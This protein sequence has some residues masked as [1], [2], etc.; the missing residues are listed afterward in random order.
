MEPKNV[1]STKRDRHSVAIKTY[2]RHTH[3]QTDTHTDTQTD[4][5]RTCDRA[6]Q[7]RGEQGC[8]RP[9][10]DV[11]QRLVNETVRSHGVEHPRDR[12]QGAYQAATMKHPLV[13][14]IY[15]QQLPGALS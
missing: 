9:G 1:T 13:H 10:V 4:S 14:R 11:T 6:P 7:C 12:E 2:A 3:R 15:L 5:A 8:V